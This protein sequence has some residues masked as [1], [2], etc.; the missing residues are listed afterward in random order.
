MASMKFDT[1][2]QSFD[3]KCRKKIF[4]DDF[5]ARSMFLQTDAFLRTYYWNPLKFNDGW[6]I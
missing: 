2:L 5:D 3:L 6:K 4:Y 1:T